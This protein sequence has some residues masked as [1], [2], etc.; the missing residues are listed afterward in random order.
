MTENQ[1]QLEIRA[2]KLK[3]KGDEGFIP[4]IIVHDPEAKL[5]RTYSD[6]ENLC[7]SDFTKAVSRL[8]HHIAVLTD[9]ITTDRFED[10]KDIDEIM[11]ARG[12]SYSGAEME[13]RV[14]L[15][16]YQKT[17]RGGTFQINTPV[18]YMETED[19]DKQYYFIDDLKEKLKRIALEARLYIFSGKRF[20]DPQLSLTLADPPD[21]GK[22]KVT[23]AKIADP[24][25]K[26]AAEIVEEANNGKDKKGRN[27]RVA[28][29]A[30]NKSGI[31]DE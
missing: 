16:G 19:E 7:H 28:Q 5:N 18:V 9:K 23:K 21:D 13:L 11:V 6:C 14:T 22:K 31:A 27:K 8:N 25:G 29:T 20:E 17:S 4:E 12:F 24:I 2:V 1:S 30:E 3:R 26:V 10:D 15:N